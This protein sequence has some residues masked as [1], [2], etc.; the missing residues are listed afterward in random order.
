[1]FEE[2]Y[3][4]E[5]FEERNFIRKKCPGCGGHFWTLDRGMETCQDAPCTEFGFIDNPPFKDNFTTEDMRQYFMDFFAERGHTPLDRYP[6]VARWRDDVFLVH[7]SIY[8]F[9]PHATSGRVKPPANP[10]I[11]SQPCIRMPDL[12]EVGRTGKHMTSF[13]MVGHH[14]FNSP[15][16]HVYWKDETVRYCH[17]L[18]VELG[19]DEKEIAYKEHPWIG[20]GNAGPSLEVN[21]RGLELATLVFMNLEKNKEGM[22][23]L[24]GDNYKPLELNV[25]DTGYGL[26]RWVWMSDGAPT[27]YDSI[28]PEIVEYICREMGFSHPL[29]DPEYRYMLEEYTRLAGRM[30]S[31]FSDG[32]LMGVLVEKMK[33]RGY[34]PDTSKLV[35]QLTGLKSVYTIADHSRTIAFML[36]DGVVP[37]NVAEGYLARLMIRRTLRHIDQTGTDISL[38]EVVKKQMEK[39]SDIIDTGREPTVMDMLDSEIERYTET[40]DKGKRLIKRHV[41]KWKGGSLSL[42]DLIGFYDSHGI[43][44]TIVKE[45]AEKLG[46]TVDIPPN[47]SVILAKRHEKLDDKEEEDVFQEYDLPETEMNYYKEQDRS[48][49]E[50]EVLYATNGEVILDRT[51]FY[52]EG[53]GQMTDTGTLET[54]N[55]GILVKHVRKEGDVIVH[56]VEGDLP[57][58]GET[59]SCCLDWERRMSLTRNHSA[60]HIIISSARKVLGDHIWQRGAHKSPETARL[61]ISHHRKITHKELMDIER[62]A[63][64]I[65]LKNIPVERDYMSRDEAEKKYGFELYQGGVPTSD[66]IRVVHIS[67]VEDLDA[68][69]CGGTHVNSTGEVG[70]IKI[71][72]AQRI[73]DG[74]VRL[75]FSAG[76]PAVDHVQI[77]EELLFEAADTF[78]VDPERL[79]E[80]AERFFQEWKERG[81]ELEKLKEYRSMALVDGLVPGHMERGVEFIVSALEDIEVKEML[82]AAESLSSQKNRIILLASVTDGVQLVF[83]RSDDI[84]IDMRDILREAAKDINGGGGGT[85][86]TAQGGGKKIEGVDSA[87]EKARSLI[88]KHFDK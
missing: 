9:Q 77:M 23:E 34:R 6:V 40:I 31:D 82:A 84:D 12:D 65:V 28:Y 24:D 59:V 38:K 2:E 52:P 32:A 88:L 55:G 37:S 75:T 45:V 64:E 36:A 30:K 71:L 53:G 4:L 47:F 86:K 13:E 49:L 73:Q 41:E 8:D 68:Q 1:M 74:V 67:G 44:P 85:P 54:K 17:D 78:D 14:A 72:G 15:D 22:I 46:V 35:E 19:A 7:A 58:V 27:I 69:A 26:E 60:T 81:K 48:C 57:S 10:L 11:V 56:E 42:E 76:M 21:L 87:L 39:F 3:R 61:D 43:H 83:S 33:E 50:A 70:F 63:N 66:I 80:T 16:N 51:C 20:G 79:P 62:L 18:L 25:V 5:F 29:D